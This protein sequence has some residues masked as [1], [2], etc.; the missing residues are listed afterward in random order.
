[1]SAFHPLQTLRHNPDVSDSLTLLARMH[2]T[3]AA[4]KYALGSLFV[5]AGTLAAPT[6]AQQP[7]DATCS[8]SATQASG[9]TPGTD[10]GP[11]GSRARGAARGAAAGAAAGA[12]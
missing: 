12:V 10:A 5:V 9:Y 1:M 11:D 4:M 7:L 6:A 2:R 3:E 8:A